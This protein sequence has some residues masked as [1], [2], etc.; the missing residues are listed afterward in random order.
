MMMR[1]LTEWMAASDAM[2][3]REGP[4]DMWA[5]INV[6]VQTQD[7]DRLRFYDDLVKGKVVLINFMFT[8]CTNQCPLTT[9]NLVKIQD[10]LGDRLGRDVHMISVTV[11]A[12]ADTPR[13]LKK[14][15]VA[16]GVKPGWRFVTGRQRDVDLIRRRL[17]VLDGSVDKSQH[18]GLLVYGND[19]TGQ[20]AATPAM[21]RPD[22][23]VRSVM[24]LASRPL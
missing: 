14:F 5:A 16:F 7:G 9:G 13:V 10:L 17:G 3:A 20:W 6:P 21:A 22:A 8:T 18:T 24:R 4:N 19:A 12:A 15:A 11:D 23:I 1:I 2:L